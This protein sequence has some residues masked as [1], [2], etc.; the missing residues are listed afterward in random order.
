MH[1]EQ[2]GKNGCSLA[3][4]QP[5]IPYDKDEGHRQSLRLQHA[6]IDDLDARAPI[7]D[8][9]GVHVGKVDSNHSNP[10]ERAASAEQTESRLVLG[11]L[12]G[13]AAMTHSLLSS[14]SDEEQEAEALREE[15]VGLEES[16]VQLSLYSKSKVRE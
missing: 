6:A 7:P 16:S 14:D 13:L 8:N 10:P 2:S 4:C 12:Q 1:E 3:G 15:K 5:G 9:L 11:R